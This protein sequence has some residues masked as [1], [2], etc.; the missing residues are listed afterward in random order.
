MH[1][2]PNHHD[3]TIDDTVI[4]QAL[5]AECS[6]LGG[7]MLDNNAFD[8]VCEVVSAADFMRAAHGQIYKCIEELA[9]QNQP[10]DVLTLSEVLSSKALLDEMGG[11]QYLS[12]SVEHCPSAANVVAYG[13]LVHEKALQRGLIGLGKDL[14]VAAKAPGEKSATQVGDEFEQKLYALGSSN[15]KKTGVTLNEALKN[16]LASLE[17]RFNNPGVNLG[18]STG[19]TDL[20]T[21]I[22]G[23]NPSDLIIIAARPSMGKTS[24]AMNLVSAA[25]LAKKKVVVFSLEMSEQQLTERLI[26]SI[27]GVSLAKIKD[28]SKLE[29]S[30]W[31]KVTA[32]YTMLNDLDIIIDDSAGLSPTQVRARCRL[33]ARQ[34]GGLDMVMVDYLGLMQVPSIKNNRTEEVSVI[35]RSLKALAKE[36][37]C[38]VL[39][40]SQLNREVEKRPDKR[41]TMADLRDSGAI[42]QDADLIMFIYRDEVYNEDSP[43]KGIAEII[44][45][46]HRNGEIGTTRLAWIGKFTKFGN[47]APGCYVG[48]E[49]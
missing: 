41:P 23:L 46:K 44:R 16:A 21:D 2:V 39:A 28:P 17:H 18:I 11:V 33:Y 37:D 10:F 14:Q 12:D 34:M 20:D 32:A 6:V 36:F 47:L 22:S 45:A 38:P 3:L 13:Q 7:L 27:G 8:N 19:F 42:E 25:G 9:R 40:L 31:A 30:D 5:S 26:A 48:D 49:D 4:P 35:S 24:F 15:E 1:S 29:D 43:Q